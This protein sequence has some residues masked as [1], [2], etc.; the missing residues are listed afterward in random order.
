MQKS[1]KIKVAFGRNVPKRAFLAK[2]D[3]ILAKNGQK[4]ENKNFHPEIFSP[5]FKRPKN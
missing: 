2:S 3:Q 4:V 5:F 1:E